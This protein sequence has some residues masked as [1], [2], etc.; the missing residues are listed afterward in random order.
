MSP[1]RLAKMRRGKIRKRPPLEVA[2]ARLID[3][4]TQQDLNKT[5]IDLAR[6]DVAMILRSLL[7]EDNQQ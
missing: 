6:A 2:C 4:L 1:T 5:N 7:W 3:A